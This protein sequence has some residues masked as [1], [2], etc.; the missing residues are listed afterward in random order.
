[1]HKNL[2]MI[3]PIIFILS[4][5]TYFFGF[6]NNAGLGRDVNFLYLILCTFFLPSPK[7]QEIK[8]KKDRAKAVLF[9][10]I[11]FICA[12][13]ISLRTGMRGEPF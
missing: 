3:L 12:L 1:M 7:N 9:L 2:E 11:S 10:V 13:F 4:I 5:I 8:A 6:V